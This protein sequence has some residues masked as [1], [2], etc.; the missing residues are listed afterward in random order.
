[1][2]NTFPFAFAPA[3]MILYGFTSTRGST[4]SMFGT[5]SMIASPSRSETPSD[6]LRSSPRSSGFTSFARTITL[7]KPRRPIASSAFCSAPAPME[8]MAITAPTPKIIP[9]IVSVVRSLCVERL[10]SAV[11]NVSSR[12]IGRRSRVVVLRRIL[13]RDLVSVDQSFR[14]HHAARARRADRHHRGLELAVAAAVEELLPFLLEQRLPRDRE[15][16]GLVL[17]FERSG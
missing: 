5:A 8:S 2:P 6:F 16:A 10:D 3:A 11:R 17:D 4:R 9:S 15:R 12:I 13:E 1:M 7:R 14:D